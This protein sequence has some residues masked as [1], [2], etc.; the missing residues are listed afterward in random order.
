MAFFNG[1]EA[2]LWLGIAAVFVV[3]LL[4][5][6]VRRPWRRL[7]WGS[8]FFL[9]L[10]GVSDLVEVHTGAWWEPWWLGL[11]KGGCVAYFFFAALYYMRRNRKNPSSGNP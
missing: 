11:W 8:A 3:N 7:G 9:A 6:R 4:S 1:C 2:A 10:F 5:G